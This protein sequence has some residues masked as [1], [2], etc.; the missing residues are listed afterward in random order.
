MQYIS[1]ILGQSLTAHNHPLILSVFFFKLSLSKVT[2]DGAPRNK[3]LGCIFEFLSWI[4][5]E[6]TFDATSFD[7]ACRSSEGTHFNSG[8]HF[9]QLVECFKE[10]SGEK[11]RK[12]HTHK[13][14]NLSSH[15]RQTLNYMIFHQTRKLLSFQS[16][17]DCWDTVSEVSE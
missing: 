4:Y 2:L 10:S 9:S 17:Q 6:F 13:S 15:S 12:S 3:Y 16:C 14:F 1:N 11:L 5:P 8:A 7:T